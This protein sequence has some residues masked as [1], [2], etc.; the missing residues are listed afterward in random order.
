MAAVMVEAVVVAAAVGALAFLW[1][2]EGVVVSL[3]AAVRLGVEL[4]LEG[5]KLLRNAEEPA[6][7]H[8]QD[9]PNYI[10]QEKQTV[11]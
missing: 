10:C 11:L 6:D 1:R 2:G 5:G 4:G 8:T 9:Y 3:Q 7:L